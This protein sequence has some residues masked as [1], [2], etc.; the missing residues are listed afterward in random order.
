MDQ[1]AVTEPDDGSES[2]IRIPVVRMGGTVDVITVDWEAS[3]SGR[4]QP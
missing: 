4:H 1:L 2:E 3:L